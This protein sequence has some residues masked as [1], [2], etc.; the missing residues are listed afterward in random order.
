[1]NQ[2]QKPTGSLSERPYIDFFN[3]HL[4]RRTKDLADC[5]DVSTHQLDPSASVAG[6]RGDK[7]SS[8]KDMEAALRV[9][10]TLILRWKVNSVVITQQCESDHFTFTS[11]R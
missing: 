7:D 9:E 2:N 6:S 5:P 11:Q 10:A 1:L 3:H 4:A 8:V